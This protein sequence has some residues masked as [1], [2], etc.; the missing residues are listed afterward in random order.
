MVVSG[1]GESEKSVRGASGGGLAS[2]TLSAYVFKRLPLTR[3]RFL[4]GQEFFKT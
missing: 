3:R 4:N 2:H 1:G